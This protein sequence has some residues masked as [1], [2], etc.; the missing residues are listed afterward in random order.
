[1]IQMRV[2]EAAG[3]GHSHVGGMAFSS[4]VAGGKNHWLAEMKDAKGAR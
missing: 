1:M 2:A 3:D 4:V